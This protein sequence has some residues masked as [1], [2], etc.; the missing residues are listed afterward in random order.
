MPT[1]NLAS[2][3]YTVKSSFTTIHTF[4]TEHFGNFIV[5][6]KCRVLVA[7]TYITK[8][9]W[10]TSILTFSAET[11]RGRECYSVYILVVHIFRDNDDTVHEVGS[12]SY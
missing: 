1:K 12:F 9:H 11:M 8:L 6:N 5:V 4:L 7:G 3:H 2:Y 10:L